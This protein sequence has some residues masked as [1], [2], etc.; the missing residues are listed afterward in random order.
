MTTATI[1]PPFTR[2]VAGVPSP[3]PAPRP[4]PVELARLRVTIRAVDEARFERMPAGVALHA[5]LHR[6][7]EQADRSYAHQIH[8]VDTKPLVIGPL[9]RADDGLPAGTC[10]L[11]GEWATFQLA[12]L[13]ARSASVALSVLATCRELRLNWAAV[14]IERVEP[15]DWPGL[16][17]M[18][19]Y[20]AILD[21]S[22]PAPAIT[23]AFRSPTL[24]RNRGAALFNVDPTLVFGSFLRRWERFSGLPLPGLNLDSITAGLALGDRELQPIEV[25]LRHQDAPV[26]C[27]T[28]WARYVVRGDDQFRAGVGALASYAAWCGAG[29]RTAYG[30]G[31]VE[32]L[33]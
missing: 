18:T 10:L 33:R 12:T 28:G 13:D 24:F 22:A 32:R 27:L 31:Q 16:P 23:L 3:A 11:P 8:S 15:L 20:R 17:A 14:S 1:A 19:G 9:L 29:G 5:A 4:A 25:R 30:L 6:A 2:L 26:T 7:L 21:A